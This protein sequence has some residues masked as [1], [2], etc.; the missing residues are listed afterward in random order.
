MNHIALSSDQVNYLVFRYLKESGFDHSAWVFNEESKASQLGFKEPDIRN[1]ELIKVIQE[2]L[3]LR[4]L[5]LHSRSDG[6]TIGC[7]VPVQLIGTHKCDA[8]STPNS[9]EEN[10]LMNDNENE[11]VDQRSSPEVELTKA[12]DAD[13]RN[14]SIAQEVILYEK[15]S[16]RNTQ[17]IDTLHREQISE[18]NDSKNNQ[19][20]NSDD[21]EI[22]VPVSPPSPALIVNKNTLSPLYAPPVSQSVP[23]KKPLSSRTSPMT[24]TI[25]HKLE[26]LNHILLKVPGEELVSFSWKPNEDVLATGGQDGILRIWHIPDFSERLQE[27]KKIEYPPWLNEI[28]TTQ[29]AFITWL[30]WHPT[31]DDLIACSYFN[32][33]STVYKINSGLLHRKLEEH[34]ASTLKIKWS[35]KGFRVLTA[36]CDKNVICWDRDGQ[37]MRFAEVHKETVTDVAW[38]DDRIFASCS[39]DKKIF[40]W[41]FKTKERPTMEFAGHDDEVFSIKWDPTKNYLAS[42]SKD[43]KC[44]IWSE[45]NH[46][47]LQTLQTKDGPIT[48]AEWHPK[49]NDNETLLLTTSQN[50]GVVRIWSALEGICLRD[51]SPH[52]LHINAIEFCSNGQYFATG[53]ADNHLHI[54]DAKTYKIRESHFLGNDIMSI[55]WNHNCTKIAATLHNGTI[56][57]IKAFSNE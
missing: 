3:Q 10:M 1:G 31:Q 32:G 28:D 49:S 4:D 30:D 57:I 19:N 45:G 54:I 48:C 29:A 22:D 37:A 38:K 2:G 14:E 25:V 36:S 53:S 17:N 7:N 33:L 20:D 34:R 9:T 51:F 23:T 13:I 35:P 21:M 11:R 18:L 47:P 26:S 42:C 39:N 15:E 56:Y 27:P 41:D 44:K 12:N 46:A 5:T 16:K 52:K 50:S 40:L 8:P 24:N 43:G 6:R 55:K